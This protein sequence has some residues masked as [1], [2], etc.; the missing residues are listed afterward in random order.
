MF[1]HPKNSVQSFNNYTNGSSNYG[2]R[3]VSD[4]QFASKVF[5]DIARKDWQDYKNTF[6]PVHQLFSDA[7]MNDDLTKQQLERVPG[8]IEQ[9][10]AQVQ[11]QMDARNSRMGL[12]S[13]ESPN[14]ASSQGL[15]TVFA[16]NQAR[17]H[18]KERRMAAIA[19]A[20]ITPQDTRVNQ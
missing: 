7:V 1:Q 10:F 19:G 17:S 20:N 5:G 15:A 3:S 16:E 13:T 14:T 4:D 6:M 2:G 9:Q 11:G 8:N 12:A 18:G